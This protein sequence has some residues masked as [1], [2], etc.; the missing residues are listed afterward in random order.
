MFSLQNPNKVRALIGVFSGNPCAFHQPDG[1]GYA[2]VAEQVLA[3]DKLNPQ[4]AS[5]LA[6]SLMRW[7]KYSTPCRHKMHEQLERIAH[8]G[9]FRRC[10]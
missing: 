8:G 5:R 7:Q 2:F 1:S 4:A 10:V 3:L 9:S 6:R